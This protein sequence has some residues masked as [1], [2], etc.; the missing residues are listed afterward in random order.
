SRTT[1][2]SN[3]DPSATAGGKQVA[4]LLSPRP[5][6]SPAPACLRRPC[7]PSVSITFGTSPR[8]WECQKSDPDNSD[9]CSSSVSRATNSAGFTRSSWRR[10]CAQEARACETAPHPVRVRGRLASRSGL[11][12]FGLLGSRYA[13]HLDLARL[14]LLS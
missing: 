8:G 7:G 2:T 10:G 12:R 6:W 3:D 5:R 4:G 13:G 1:S 9:A 11:D 14:R